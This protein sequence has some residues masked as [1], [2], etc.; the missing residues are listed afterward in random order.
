ML[1]KTIK[2]FGY[3]MLS[4]SLSGCDP[5]PGYENRNVKGYKPVYASSTDKAIHFD[6]PK[7]IHQPGKIYSYGKYLL[8]NEV[9]KG[10]HFFAVYDCCA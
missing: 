4:F 8:I 5:Y 3:F 1:Y 10:I 6:A 7:E 2:V 9:E